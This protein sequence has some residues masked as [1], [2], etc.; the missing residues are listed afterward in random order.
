[1]R[2]AIALDRAG[3]VEI[4]QAGVAEAVDAVE[5]AQNLLDQ[6]LALAIRVGG[7]ELCSLQNG[8]ADRL[9][10]AGRGRTEHQ[11]IVPS[12]Q[13]G[14]QQRKRPRRVV[15]EIDL[16]SLHAFARLDQCGEVHNPLK[17]PG[18]KRSFKQR[19]VGQIALDELRAGRYCRP[20]TVTEIVKNGHGMAAAQQNSRHGTA[21]IPSTAC[22]Q[23]LHRFS[24]HT[25]FALQPKYRE[26][27]AKE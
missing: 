2:L 22:Y 10:I 27:S 19:P 17:S 8:S 18:I 23:N 16:R 26:F 3:D 7:L 14:L 20:L 1:M 11:P 5:P 6:Q 12:S 25:P 4:P 24:M 15:A 13:H 9:A 21:D